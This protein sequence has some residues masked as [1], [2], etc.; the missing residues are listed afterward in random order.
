MPER[1]GKAIGRRTA[2]CSLALLLLCAVPAAAAV[3]EPGP[4]PENGNPGVLVPG[5]TSSRVLGAVPW[6]IGPGGFV[7]HLKAT[8]PWAEAPQGAAGLLTVE[9][10]ACPGQW[11]AGTCAEGARTVIPH[12]FLASP[13]GTLSSPAGPGPAIPAGAELLAEVTLSPAADD[14]VQGLSFRMTAGDGVR[15]GAG[16]QAAAMQVRDGG[17]L[18]GAGSPDTVLRLAGLALLGAAAA[19]TGLAATGWARRL[20]LQG[21]SDGPAGAPSG[22]PAAGRAGA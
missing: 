19:V 1:T 12:T 11:T 17:R 7:L 9:V 4:S 3:P 22:G 14:A 6:E 8:G 10:K 16:C 21:P 2:G 15:D 20:N 5:S 13:D 18:P